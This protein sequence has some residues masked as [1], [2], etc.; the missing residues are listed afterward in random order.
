M[1]NTPQFG[2]TGITA[3]T[4][5]PGLALQTLQVPGAALSWMEKP[6]AAIGC[7]QGLEYLSQLDQV[8]VHQ[9]VDMQEVLTN[10]ETA[11]KYHVKNIL[12][13]QLHRGV[14]Q[15]SGNKRGFVMHIMDNMNQEV[16]KVSREYKCCVGCCCACCAGCCNGEKCASKAAVEAPPGCPIG[17]VVQRPSLCGDHLAIL[18]ENH[19]TLL[20][21]RGPGCK[22]RSIY[23]DIE[24]N[25]LSSDENEELGKISKQWAGDVQEVYTKAD[26]YGIQFQ[27]NLEVKSKAILLGAV[28]LI[29]FMFFE[30]QQTVHQQRTNQQR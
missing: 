10:L 21:I 9:Q 26:N 28:I 13:Q 12:G 25:V 18:D 14:I 6:P 23:S 27:M 1:A 24:F 30:E 11:N 22:C 17:Y 8:L 19:E 20:K 2:M 15:I 5:I 3:V 29:D 16:M 7:P 4:S